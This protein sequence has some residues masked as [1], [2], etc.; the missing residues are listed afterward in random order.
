LDSL[1]REEDFQNSL[2]LIKL[3]KHLPK[4]NLD[5]L[6]LL[7]TFEN[8]S[9]LVLATDRNIEY[10]ENQLEKINNMS[11]KEIFEILN[12][13]ENNTVKHVLHGIIDQMHVYL[14]LRDNVIDENIQWL[15]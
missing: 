8:V 12:S 3:Y 9:G 4:E 13:E 11:D 2:R 6:N 1:E 5:E 7:I 15:V 10:F 14:S